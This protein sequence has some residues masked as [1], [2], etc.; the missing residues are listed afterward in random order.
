MSMKRRKGKEMKS[1]AELKRDAKK[2][3]IWMEMVERFGKTGEDIPL[4]LRG[5][6]LLVGA[7]NV[8]IFFSNANGEKS[9]CRIARASLIDYD[10]NGLTVYGFGMRPMNA[11]ET[12]CWVA[13]EEYEQSDEYKTLVDNDVRFGWNRS[14]W[15]KKDF[16]TVRGFPYLV[17][18]AWDKYGKKRDWNT[19]MIMDKNVRG[20]AILKY[21]IVESA[22][23]R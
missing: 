19:G 14:W 16:F 22:P 15:C 4:R 9:E 1:F 21:R 20:D 8:A 13:W 3:T 7:N 5:P 10:E 2:G 6:R 17:T 11:D 18:D 12:K 23:K